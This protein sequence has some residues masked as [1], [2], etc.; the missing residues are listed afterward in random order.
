MEHSDWEAILP[1]RCFLR[2]GLERVE[3]AGG[4]E[5]KQAGGYAVVGVRAAP[6][7]NTIRWS[8]LPR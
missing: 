2:S 3:A 8:L 1:V 6:G 4:E 7:V 5:A